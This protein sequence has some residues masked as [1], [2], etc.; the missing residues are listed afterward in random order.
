MN[1]DPVKRKFFVYIALAV[2][3]FAVYWQVNQYDFIN[4]DDVVFVTQNNHIQ[5]G[6]TSE[7]VRW[8]LGPD[9]PIWIPF[10]WFSLMFDHQL[11]GMNAGGYHVTNLFLHIMSTL[12]LFWLFNR[13]TGKL[14]RSAFVAALFALH[15]LHVESVAWIAERKDVLSA[16]F[17]MLTLCLYVWYTDKPVAGRYLPVLLSFVFALMSKP[18]VI[19]LPVVMILLD[20]WPLD[21]LHSRKIMANMQEVVPAAAGKGKK[22]NKVKKETIQENT[23]VPHVQKLQEPKLWG[24]IPLW[25]IKEKLPFLVLSAVLIIFTFGNQT[26]SS[27]RKALYSWEIRM[28]NVPVAF[29]T[30]LEK[31][32]LPHDMAVF[33][34]VSTPPAW[35]I[36]GASMLIILIT[37]FVI[38]MAK[39]LPYLFVGWFWYAVTIA[40]V[41]GIIQIGPHLIADRYHYLPSIGIAVMLAWGVPLLMP[42]EKIR[43]WILFPV[44]IGFLAVLTFLT[45]RQCGYWTNSITLFDHAV[46]V[47]Q[48]NAL[49]HGNL[50][51]ALFQEGKN[52][53]A[54]DN[55]SKSIE[56][57]PDYMMAYAC[58]GDVYAA[59]GQYN[60]AIEDYNRAL[61]LKPD[62]AE[63]YNNRGVAYFKLNRHK[64][65]IDDYSNALKLNGEYTDAYYNR[66]NA[67]NYLGQLQPAIADYNEALSR[68][69]DYARCYQNRGIAYLKLNDQ[70]HG[71]PDVIKACTLGNCGTLA[72]AKNKGF[73]R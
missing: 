13:M 72:E 48:D 23:S 20:Y 18:M 4:Y 15:P 14:W 64:Q 21:R 12:L 67:Y 36:I 62:R 73:C 66:G 22:K 32:F 35:Q 1:I 26:I 40:P 70:Q 16:F 28:A 3:T 45:W 19:T 17:W 54:M 41:I 11:H 71:C 27:G 47:T 56:V 55:L 37:V 25:Q 50:G 49:A 68:K 59:N 60:Q 33:Y 9:F 29:M 6:F 52:K 44:G 8:A 61:S 10:V 30:Y 42:A 7:G 53:E 24:V 31:T 51:V 38:I 46:R 58:R 57:D 34:P 43:Q 39:R 69:P 5:S 2:V 65:A 63:T